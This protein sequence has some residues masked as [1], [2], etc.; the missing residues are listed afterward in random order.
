MNLIRFLSVSK[1]GKCPFKPRHIQLLYE[2]SHL[3]HWLFARITRRNEKT[4]VSH[5]FIFGEND[6]D[7]L[8][9]IKDGGFV[10]GQ[11]SR[12]R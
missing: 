8:E 2:L 10:F 1:I 9:T 3:L 11:F 5:V 12:S 7:H 4:E 6:R